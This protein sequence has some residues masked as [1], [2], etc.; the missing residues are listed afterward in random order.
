MPGTTKLQYFGMSPA[1]ALALI[2]ADKDDLLTLGMSATDVDEL[3]R[4]A[5]WVVQQHAEDVVAHYAALHDAGER[6]AL[7][8]VHNGETND[9]GQIRR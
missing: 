7:R 6:T 9:G 8:L 5:R 1:E 3:M 2:A 4:A